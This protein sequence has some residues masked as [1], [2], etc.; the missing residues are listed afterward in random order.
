MAPPT[1]PADGS[2]RRG[3]GN[4]LLWYLLL[5][6]L[7]VWQGWMTLSLFGYDHPWERLLDEQ[8]IVSGRHPLHLY[9]G[10]LG[11]QSL[12]N[13]GTLCSYDPAFQAGYPKTPVFDS[14]S[15][16]AEL[17][18]LV[19]G[20]TYQ[21]AAYKLGLALCYALVPLLLAIAA[22]SAG[23]PRAGAAMSALLG[24]LVWWG[25][26]CRQALEAGQFNLL[27]AT[28]AALLQ[29]SLLIRYDCSPGFLVWLGIVASGYLG[30][31][32]HPFFFALLVP[33]GLIYY[34]S[35]GHRH[36]LIWHL[37][38]LIGL[39]GAVAIN[40]FWL[41]DWFNYW[42]I[43]SPLRLEP[44]LLAHRTFHTLWD[45]VIWGD[46]ADRALTIGLFVAACVGVW[47]F[48]QCHQ[49]PAARL[50]GLAAAGFLLLAIAGAVWEAPGSL[51]TPV[52]VVPGLLFAVPLAVHALLEGA[53]LAA[54]CLGCRW[55]GAFAVG[56]LLL[57][58]GGLASSHVSTFAGRCAGTTPLVIGLS[59]E[60]LELAETLRD[61]TTPEA[62]ILWEDHSGPA[63]A[64]HWTPLLPLL[65]E[66]AFIGGLDPDA[67]IEYAY[68]NFTDQVL[69]GR[70]LAD[71][72]DAELDDFCRSYNIGWIVCWSPGAIERF[73]TWKTAMAPVPLHDEQGPGCLFRLQRP[74]TFA[75]RGQAQW[76]RADCQRIILGDVIPENGE[77]HLSLHYQAGM[78]ASPQ[79]VQ[80]ERELDPQ[81]PIP[82]VR[83]RLTEPVARVTLTWEGGR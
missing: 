34:L 4:H 58:L 24:L 36:T 41:M 5:A 45:S 56:S 78:R 8:P 49:R 63:Q 29:M 77:V 18:L 10:A 22:R 82:F 59:P 15:R 51:G 72:T 20:G 47:R 48:N 13:H 21:P 17:F 37:A 19:G 40:A 70:P 53:R 54:R 74:T 42:W 76:L 1:Q 7:V 66:R 80:I 62:R 9:H 26:P 81:D 27:M 33:L 65:T 71:W 73:R 57:A 79:R 64:Q 68:A 14:G 46:A 43:R 25:H 23:L 28:L 44:R 83:L 30:W 67:C 50:L 60:R 16:P 35:V 69:G 11:A 2:A 12:L 3:A 31:F 75:L 32:T 52:L 39:S 6:G 55:R 61:Q 38:L